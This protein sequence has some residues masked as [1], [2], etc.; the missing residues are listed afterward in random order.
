MSD[1]LN[2]ELKAAGL[3]EVAPCVFSQYC[4]LGDVLVKAWEFVTVAHK[5]IPEDGY[6]LQL[7]SLERVKKEGENIKSS[8]YCIS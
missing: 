8:D 4:T 7:T 6:K 3:E 1:E 5:Q 2:E